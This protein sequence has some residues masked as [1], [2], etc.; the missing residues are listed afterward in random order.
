MQLKPVA[1]HCTSEEPT[2]GN[3]KALAAEKEDEGT[4]RVGWG[5][6]LGREKTGREKFDGDV[7]IFKAIN[8][9]AI[10]LYIKIQ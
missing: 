1:L 10:K 6:G 9:S 2:T 4:H 3:S 7:F 5:L 8:V